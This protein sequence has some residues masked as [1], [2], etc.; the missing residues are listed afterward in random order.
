MQFTLFPVL[1]LKHLFHCDGFLLAE[2][3]QSKRIHFPRESTGRATRTWREKESMKRRRETHISQILLTIIVLRPFRRCPDVA[4]ISI[5]FFSTATCT[6][7]GVAPP[8]LPLC[9]VP[10]EAAAPLSID[11][12]RWPCRGSAAWLLFLVSQYSR[13]Q[14]GPHLR[15]GGRPGLNTQHAK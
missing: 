11:H 4:A 1:F 7:R 10:V 12:T 8:L 9:T 6:V 13:V 14:C 5:H 3:M 15:G 2:A